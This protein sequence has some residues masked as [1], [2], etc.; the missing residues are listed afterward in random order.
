MNLP[1]FLSK[2]D[3]QMKELS[4]FEQQAIAGGDGPPQSLAF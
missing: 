2:G 3:S 4:V 1:N